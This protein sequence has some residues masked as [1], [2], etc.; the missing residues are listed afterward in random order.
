MYDEKVCG[1][2]WMNCVQ[3]GRKFEVKG[4]YMYVLHRGR[5]VCVGVGVG[6]CEW[7]SVVKCN[8]CVCAKV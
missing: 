4:L 2:V 3:D 1:C 7:E 8:W 6:V 5:C